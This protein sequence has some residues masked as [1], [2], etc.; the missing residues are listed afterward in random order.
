[1]VR[2]VDFTSA[3]L[4]MVATM[5]V[6]AGVVAQNSSNADGNSDIVVQGR[7]EAQVRSYVDKV[8]KP[9]WGRQIAR[10][11]K[12]ICLDITGVDQAHGAFIGRDIIGTAKTLGLTVAG[13]GCLDNLTIIVAGSK[14]ADAAAVQ[15]AKK[16]PR[17][18]GN[19]YDETAIQAKDI[20]I[21]EKPRPVRWFAATYTYSGDGMPM[22]GG[23][24]QQYAPGRIA[25][26]TQEQTEEV[27]VIVDA[28]KITGADW[29]Q[30]A[31]YLTLISLGTPDMAADY[32]GTDSILSIFANG[33]NT[34]A[35]PTGLTSQDRSF[36]RG[37]YQSEAARSASVQQADLRNF[38]LHD[39][40]AKTADI[41]MKP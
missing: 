12:P 21:M 23:Q 14:D 4:M 33:A 11:H 9:S 38:I 36:L 22:I 8:A 25:A 18:F 16:R 17:R 28:D 3:C 13:K 29:G 6:P 35:G 30:L 31:D 34:E 15:I 2:R 7:T 37:L 20:E 5:A 19:T 41:G 27:I 10:W 26:S 40:G 24:N 32:G 39:H 1:M